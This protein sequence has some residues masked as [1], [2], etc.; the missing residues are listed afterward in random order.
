MVSELSPPE[1][2]A[3]V[4]DFLTGLVGAFG[5]SATVVDGQLDEDTMEVRVEG[6][7]LGL[8][9]GPRGQTL[10]A[11]QE[12]ARATVQRRL[13]GGHEARVRID[14]AGYRQ[15]RREALARFAEQVAADVAASGAPKAL[16]P[17]GGAD[18]KVV[19][20]TIN[21]IVGVAT[22][23]QGEEPYRR[24]VIVPAEAAG[25]E[26]AGSGDG[27]SAEADSFEEE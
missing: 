8:L 11:V 19:H 17:M 21:E 2:A 27:G 16:E 7:E 22:V 5:L 20:D 18:R 24:V 15:R 6:D 13:A 12:L 10:Q 23:S 14:V 3:I 1:Q 26:S 9:I 4:Q 25:D